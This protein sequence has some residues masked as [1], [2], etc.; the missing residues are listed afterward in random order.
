[1]LLSV[2][3]VGVKRKL[4]FI[5]SLRDLLMKSNKIVHKFS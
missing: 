4:M 1:M 5:E 3:S 2:W